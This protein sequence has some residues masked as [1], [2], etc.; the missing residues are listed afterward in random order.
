MYTFQFQDSPEQLILLHKVTSC[1]VEVQMAQLPRGC[2]DRHHCVVPAMISRSVYIQ[3]IS[4]IL[5][6]IQSNCNVVLLVG[7]TYSGPFP[8]PKLSHPCPIPN[9]V[10]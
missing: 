10:L 4:H 3:P 7:S 8:L 6:D 1:F 9:L 5:H 2:V